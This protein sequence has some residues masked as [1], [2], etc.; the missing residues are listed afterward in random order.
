MNP[1]SAKDF[2]KNVVAVLMNL[3]LLDLILMG[4][5]L[6]GL[7]WGFRKG[8]M[9]TF[10]RLLQLVIV[11]TITLEYQ[12]YLVDYFSIASPV[13]LYVVNVVFFLLLV[14]VC[15]FVGKMFVDLI[16]RIM[17]IQFAE[18]LDR[19][20]GALFG[21]AYFVLLLSFMSSFFLLLPNEWLHENF[22]NANVSGPHMI[23][24]AKD[25]HRGARRAIPRSF[26]VADEVIK[27]NFLD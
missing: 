15:Y 3:G 20:L 10:N 22:E 9:I 18:V 21:G 7:L 14:A 1:S 12:P 2:L 27:V 11:L 16:A 4:L 5:V 8:L 13:W 24:L 26:R 19:I 17:T 25:V 6:V 23:S